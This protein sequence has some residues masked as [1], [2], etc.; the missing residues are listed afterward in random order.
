MMQQPPYHMVVFAGKVLSVH[1]KAGL[2]HAWRI[3][4]L[5]KCD[6]SPD[7]GRVMIRE[8]PFP[9]PPYTEKSSFD[10]INSLLSGEVLDTIVDQEVA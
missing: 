9:P 3:E 8:T 10:W 6:P 4:W 2:A 1:N 5:A 7:P